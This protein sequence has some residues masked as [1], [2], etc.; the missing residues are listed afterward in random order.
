M[1]AQ[2]PRGASRVPLSDFYGDS[3]KDARRDTWLWLHLRNKAGAN[4]AL[5]EFG[6]PNMRERMESFLSTP[7][8]ANTAIHHEMRRLLL[9]EESFNWISRNE[10]QI[11]WLI[12]LVNFRLWDGKFEHPPLLLGKDLIVAMID[13]W[14]ADLCSKEALVGQM[15]GSW[16]QHLQDDQIYR[17]F[18]DEDESARCSIAWE[19]L[20]KHYPAFTFRR[21]PI[22]SYEEILAFFDLKPLSKAETIL[23]IQSIKKRWSQRKYRD[24]LNGKKQ[25]NFVLSDKANLCLDQ[26][27]EKHGLTRAKILEILILE[28]KI[29]DIYIPEKLKLL[30]R[31]DSL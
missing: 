16:N 1:V 11:E 2:V 22:T 3:R 21:A 29:N 9:P 7:P 15:Q 20:Q 6:A 8:D 18:K 31:L 23:A 25:Y 12:G 13:A 19:W 17:W 14:D 27:S 4:F 5:D 30:K 10:R 24:N 26:L 28:E